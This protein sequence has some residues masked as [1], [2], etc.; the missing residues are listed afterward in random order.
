[1]S[2]VRIK[3]LVVTPI[4]FRD[5]PLL[6]ADGVHEPWALRSVI[7]LV[8][9]D[10]VI[11]LGESFGDAVHLERLAALRPHLAGTSVYA[12]GELYIKAAELFDYT[13]GSI[14]SFDLGRV[15][16]AVEVACLDV[17]GKLAGRPVS[18]LLGGAVREAVPFSAYLFYK[19]AGHPGAEPDEWGAALDPQGVVDQAR[20]MIDRYGFESIKLKG[21]VFPPDQEIAAIRALREAFPDHPLR[22]DPNVA[23]TVETSL[24]V[25]EEL[26]GVVEYLEDPVRGI[27]AMAEVAAKAPMPL[28]TNMCVVAFNQIPPAVAQ[29]AV[30]VILGDHH[31]WGGLTRTRHLGTI[32]ETFGLGMSMHSN[33]H[34]GI[35]L[36]AMTHLAAA[37][38]NLTYACDTHYP[39]SAQDDVVVPGVLEF[40]EGSLRVP[41]G[42]GLGVE[43]DQDVLGRLHENYLTCG[44][45]RRDDTGYMRRV[46]PDF[47]AELP[48]W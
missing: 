47:V 23:W 3:D 42:P 44:L 36:A 4:A 8:T 35:S 38:P 20:R 10:G 27:P 1:M 5:P 37:T 13:G 30:Q 15:H 22:L 9:E 41:T 46:N 40:T 7:Q 16:S 32:C 14:S 31:Y 11:G 39:W 25:A 17:Q 33:S 28:A 34:L 45:R 18:D 2:D 6:N 21:G 19:W 48:R 43:L 26:D 29:G 12:L 24:Q